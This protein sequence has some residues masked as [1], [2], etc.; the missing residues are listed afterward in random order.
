MGTAKENLYHSVDSIRRGYGIPFGQA[1]DMVDLLGTHTEKYNINIIPFKT[2]GLCGVAMVGDKTDTIALNSY[3]TPCERNFDCGHELVHLSRHRSRQESFNCFTSARA[4][5]NSFLE[6]EANEGSAQILVPYQDFV[7]RFALYLNSRYMHDIRGEL[8]EYYHVTS[9]VINLRI[10]N[11]GYEIDQYL[12][13]IPIE[14]IELLSRTQ[15]QKAGIRPTAYNAMCDF[16]IGWDS[17]IG[18]DR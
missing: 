14:N 11:L 15:L 12:A 18:F 13:G 10:D 6:W 17:V 2:P 9:Q 7:P 4:Q 5:Q 16:E 3:R 1:I 8:A